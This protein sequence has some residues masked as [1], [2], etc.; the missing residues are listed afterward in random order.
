MGARNARIWIR[1]IALSAFASGAIVASVC[2]GAAPVAAPASAT[3]S[4]HHGRI[5][6]ERLVGPN[7]TSQIGI[8]DPGGRN[9]RRLTDFNAGAGEPAWSPAGGRIVFSHHFKDGRPG[10]LFS[11]RAGGENRK[12]LSHGCRGQCL[13]DYEPSYAP[14]GNQIVFSRAFGPIVNDNASEIDI[15]VMRRNGTQIRTIKR[16]RLNGRNLEP[17]SAVWS[18][19]GER[20]ALMLLDATSPSK[21]SAIF[22][23]ELDTG[24]LDRVTQFHLNAGNPDWSPNGAR[25]LFNSNFEGQA[26]ANLFT[27]DPDG[28]N[29]RQLTDN[30]RGRSFFEPTWSPTGRQIAFVAAST[31][32]PPHIVKMHVGGQDKHRVTSA[33]RPGVHPDWGRRP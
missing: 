6:F 3:F 26:A 10:A 29:L 22:T 5:V 1:R 18:P 28:S 23:L 32:V 12:R 31:H 16:F 19:N 15:M 13:E 11:M 33:A 14:D 27:V 2:A 25:I 7:F 24:D 17:H 4:G 21:R 9:I 30:P 20:L 8:V